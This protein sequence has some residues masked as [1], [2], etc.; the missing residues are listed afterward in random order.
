MLSFSMASSIFVASQLWDPTVAVIRHDDIL[1]IPRSTCG[2][3]AELKDTSKWG[4]QIGSLVKYCDI[5]KYLDIIGVSLGYPWDILG[6]E[7]GEF[8]TVG[9]D[10]KISWDA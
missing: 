3:L 6:M 10:N 8:P 7:F 4:C 2:S 9:Y 1:D 5:E